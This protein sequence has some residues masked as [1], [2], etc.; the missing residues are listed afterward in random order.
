MM[1]NL[2][3]LLTKLAEEGTEVGQMALKNQHF[4]IDECQ[5]S[6]GESNRERLHGEINDLLGVI[7]LLNEE[8]GFG[9]TPDEGAIVAKMQKIRHYRDYSVS[10]GLVQKK[11]TKADLIQEVSFSRLADKWP[12]GAVAVH[13]KE[14]GYTYRTKEGAEE[15]V[16]AGFADC[17]ATFDEIFGGENA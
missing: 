8:E 7:R 2:Q 16:K 10:L 4:G 13:L 11:W 17:Y 15:M 12:L 14:G 1:S 9:F 6:G 5:F 3:Y